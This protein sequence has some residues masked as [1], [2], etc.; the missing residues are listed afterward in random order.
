MSPAE[1]SRRRSYRR[2]EPEQFEKGVLLPAAYCPL[3]ERRLGLMRLIVS[4][5]VRDDRDHPSG[6]T[7]I[8]AV[9]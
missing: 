2:Q 5:N 6:F 8:V 3:V 4:P 9:A 7:A 1:V